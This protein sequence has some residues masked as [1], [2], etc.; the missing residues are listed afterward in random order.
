MDNL[1][2]KL[3]NINTDILWIVL[4]TTFFTIEL[5]INRSTSG[6]ERGQ[7]FLHGIPLLAGYTLVNFGLAFIVVLCIQW[8][9]LNHIGIFN[10]I[11]IPYFL[12]VIVGV[13]C[14]DFLSYWFHR[15]YHTLP[16]LWRLHRV[17]HSDTNMDSTTFFR[18][19]PFDWFLDNTF[20]IT[21][22]FIF[23][24]DL[25]IIVLNFI[26]YLPLLLLHHSNFIFPNWV[27]N[28][29]GKIFVVPNFHKVH[30]HQQQEFTDSNYGNIFILWDKI[31]GT[32]KYLPVKEIKYGL[33]EFDEPNRQKFWFLLKSPFINIKPI[34]REVKKPFVNN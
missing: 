14:I 2:Q 23:G 25:N 10:Q 27:D 19:H 5:I 24:L 32:Y 8:I 4:L 1:F 31:F 15:L 18:F 3:V 16:I 13:F 17:H 28:T 7:H 26:L 22:A 20:V 30:H 34:S 33:E 6:K 11:K 29:F 21:A 12:K 9:N